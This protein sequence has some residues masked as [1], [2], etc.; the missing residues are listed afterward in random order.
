MQTVLVAGSSG[1]IGSHLVYALLTRGFNVIGYDLEAF[2]TQGHSRFEHVTGDLLNLTELRKILQNQSISGIF[3]LASSSDMGSSFSSPHNYIEEEASKMRHLLDLARGIPGLGFVIFASSCSVYGNVITGAASESDEPN[4]Q[5]PY[6][7][8]KVLV[9]KLLAESCK[10]NSFGGGILRFFNV[11]GCLP[12][13][14]LKERHEPE[15]HLLPRIVRALRDDKPISVF[16]ND[17]DTP[18][19]SAIRDYVDVMDI[20]DGL[21]KAAN[22]L[23]GSTK[24]QR[25]CETWNLGSGSPTSV[26]ELIEAVSKTMNVEATIDILAR[27]PGDPA[28]ASAQSQK[29]NAE[30]DWYPRVNLVQSIKNVVRDQNCESSSSINSEKDL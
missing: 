8:A 21:L 16:G 20:C 29:A 18:D 19:G 25:K 15:T 7:Q 12:D 1:F 28:R 26:L 11:I 22:F 30:L 14:G 6:A 10:L 17:F 24:D 13:Q 9:E 2:P 3:H 4:P 23:S 5:S 27:R